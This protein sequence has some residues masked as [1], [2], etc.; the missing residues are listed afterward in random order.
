M[1]TLFFLSLAS[2]DYERLI[3]NRARLKKIIIP[4]LKKVKTYTSNRIFI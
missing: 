2:Y 1:N 4:F 3:N